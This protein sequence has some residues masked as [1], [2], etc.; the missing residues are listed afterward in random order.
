[1][2]NPNLRWIPLLAIT[3][4]VTALAPTLLW[5]RESPLLALALFERE[6]YNLE[7]SYQI[8]VLLLVLIVIAI[9]AVMTGKA[10]L[11]YLN[12]RNR[13]GRICP[14]PWIGLKPSASDT[15]NNVGRNMAIVITSVTAVVIYFQVIRG[16]SI[17]VDLFPG[18][19]LIVVFALMNAFSEEI[20][21]RFSFVAVVHRFG[22]SPYVGQGLA[23]ATFGIVHYFGTPGGIPGVL[24]AAYIGWLLAKSMFETKGFFW[25]L[26]IHF[27]QDV[28]IFFAL[29]M[30]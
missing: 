7:I 13:D 12:L 28:V 17:H 5:M 11:S 27:L 1:M 6:S 8:T 2:T 4:I 9:V 23:A 30:K 26:T 3:L 10:G 21:F 16:E 24:M 20:I 19:A 18:L 25:A 22:Y 29:L 14:E 15:W